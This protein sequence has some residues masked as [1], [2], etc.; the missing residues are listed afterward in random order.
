M[1]PTPTTTIRSSIFVPVVHVGVSWPGPP[2]LGLYEHEYLTSALQWPLN[3]G[4]ALP[5]LAS[6]RN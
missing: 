2:E 1:V 4:G 5:T 6:N 3:K